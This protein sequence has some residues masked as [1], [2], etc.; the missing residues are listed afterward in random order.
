MLQNPDGQTLPVH[1]CSA[2]LDYPGVAPEHAYWKDSGRVEYTEVTDAAA[3]EALTTMGE[4]EGVLAALETAH[5]IARAIDEAGR[6]D[7]DEHLVINCSGRGD[8]DV[9]EAARLLG[10]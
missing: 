6:M 10:L 4:T 5:A 2:G 8:K 1:S 7:A 9:D 3:L